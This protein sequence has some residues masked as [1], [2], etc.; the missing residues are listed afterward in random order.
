MVLLVF[1]SHALIVWWLL[2]RICCH[3]S[4]LIFVVALIM[5]KL[6]CSWSVWNGCPTWR[7]FSKSYGLISTWGFFFVIVTLI[8]CHIYLF[9][10]TC[11]C[12]SAKLYYLVKQLPSRGLVYICNDISEVSLLWSH[13]T[14]YFFLHEIFW[15]AVKCITG[16]SIQAL[17]FSHVLL[18]HKASFS[19]FFSMG[20]LMQYRF[21]LSFYFCYIMEVLS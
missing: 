7:W 17:E 11:L 18:S 16:S 14:L 19:V 20:V 15:K 21:V 3:D 9:E 12:K 8:G 2:Y 1:R 13:K 5:Q 6:F 4:S 10:C